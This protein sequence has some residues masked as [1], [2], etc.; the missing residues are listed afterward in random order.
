M[1]QSGISCICCTTV[2]RRWCLPLAV[3]NWERQTYTGRCELVVVFSGPGSVED[4]LPYRPD[5]RL[6]VAPDDASLGDKHNLGAERAIHPW[7]CKWDDDDWYAPRR[8]AESL[9]IAQMNDA[10]IVGTRDLVF[11]ELIGDRRTWLYEA[12]ESRWLA[13]NTMLFQ[14]D[15]WKRVP[16][17]N[18]SSGVDTVFVR[19]ALHPDKGRARAAT[20]V[21]PG[22][23]VL[24]IHGQTTGRKVWDPKPP[25]YRPW[26]LEHVWGLGLRAYEDAFESR[27]LSL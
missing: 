8:L 24:M 5:V 4:L 1:I 9:R 3:R 6:V 12:T 26:R 22:L 11:H 16:F 25:E 14:R 23:C 19:D 10:E 2:E 18:R 17:P 15:L 7:L 27:N 20:F 13:G 21:D